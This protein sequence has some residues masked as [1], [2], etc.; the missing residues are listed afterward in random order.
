MGTKHLPML[1]HGKGGFEHN[2]RLGTT[3][4][5]VLQPIT[6]INLTI[7]GCKF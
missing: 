5:N 7:N 1:V 6:S 2:Q 3:V 4:E